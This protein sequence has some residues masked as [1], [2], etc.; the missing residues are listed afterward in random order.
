MRIRYKQFDETRGIYFKAWHYEEWFCK[1]MN[2]IDFRYWFCECH[3]Q[4]PYGRV[5]SGDCKKHD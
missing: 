3:Y 1:L 5:I 2:L 4:A